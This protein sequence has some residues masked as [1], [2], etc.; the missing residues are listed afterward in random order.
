MKLFRAA[1]SGVLVLVIGGS[2]IAADTAA[3]MLYGNGVIWL[4]GS[5]IPTSSAVFPGDL[6]QTNRDSV[7]NITCAS[8]SVIVLSDSLVE[9]QSNAVKLDHGVLTVATSKGMA[10]QAGNVTVTPTSNDWTE[11]DVKNVDGT[12][13]IVARKGDLIL[14]DEVGTTTLSQG[15]QASR[16]AS[17]TNK[18]TK[19]R[20]GAAPAAVDSL[21]RQV[22]TYIAAGT[23]ATLTTWVLMQ[24]DDPISPSKFKT[25]K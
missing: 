16:S 18:G 24:G 3:A 19:K 15:Q 25:T 5:S 10:T 11:F 14:Q 21:G 20:T 2:A 1:L 9:F 7:A 17:G 4:N 22:A 8:T 13:Q 12:V 23:A 6:I